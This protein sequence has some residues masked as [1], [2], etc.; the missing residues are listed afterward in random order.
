M[1]PLQTR[2]TPKWQARPHGTSRA[3]KIKSRYWWLSERLMYLQCIST[4]DT[5]VLHSAIAIYSPDCS[6]NVPQDPRVQRKKKGLGEQKASEYIHVVAGYRCMP[7]T[8]WHKPV[9]RRH[10]PATMLFCWQKPSAY[11]QGPISQANHPNLNPFSIHCHG[12]VLAKE[13]M[14]HKILMA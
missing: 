13:K 9:T 11:W 4:G 10:M 7:N 6:W 12:K 3:C 2:Y 1:R 14:L 8:L 5:S